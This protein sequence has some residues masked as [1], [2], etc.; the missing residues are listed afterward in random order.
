MNIAQLSRVHSPQWLFGTG[1]RMN[2]ASMC[3]P[4]LV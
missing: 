2:S 3:S 1:K 4:V